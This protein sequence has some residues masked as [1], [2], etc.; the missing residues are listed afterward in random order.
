[1]TERPAHVDAVVV[2]AGFAG[3]YAH[4]RLRRLGLTIQ[5]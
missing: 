1:V 5:G 3:L 4:H 2:G